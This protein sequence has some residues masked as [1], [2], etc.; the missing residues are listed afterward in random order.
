MEAM[1]GHIQ[2]QHAEELEDNTLSTLMSWSAVQVMGITS[3]PFCSSYGPEDAPDLVDHVLREAY[4]FALRA[5]P[6]PKPATHE[7]NEL[8]GTFKLPNEE[9]CENP[10]GRWVKEPLPRD[11]DALALNLELCAYDRYD[12]PEP[13]LTNFEYTSY[14]DEGGY[15]DD[16]SEDKSSRRQGDTSSAVESE[17]PGVESDDGSPQPPRPHNLDHDRVEKEIEVKRYGITE[18]YHPPEASMELVILLVSQCPP[19]QHIATLTKHLFSL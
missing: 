18:L 12:D 4:Q 10:F 2:S 14:F 11:P 9:D 6:W 1:G 7:P 17:S 19:T 16:K 8:L 5:L 13:Q 3:C 15:F